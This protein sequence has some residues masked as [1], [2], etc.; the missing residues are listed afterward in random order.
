MAYMPGTGWNALA[1]GL[2]GAG[3]MFMN[4]YKMKEAERQQKA[5]DEEAATRLGLAT[6]SSDLAQKTYD[7]QVRGNKIAEAESTARLQLAQRDELRRLAQMSPGVRVT[8]QTIAQAQAAGMDMGQITDTRPD[9]TEMSVK[10][11]LSSS[12][13]P[14]ALGEG[15]IP[16]VQ[17]QQPEAGGTFFRTDLLTP[18]ERMA[19]QEMDLRL[20]SFAFDKEKQAELVRQFGV[21]MAQNAQRIAIAWDAAKRA[22][23]ED[24]AARAKEKWE[25]E[26][27]W[28]VQKAL[29]E[30]HADYYRSPRGNSGL[31][32]WLL[33]QDP[34]SNAPR[35]GPLSSHGDGS[36]ERPRR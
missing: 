5:A 15:A 26:V 33:N 1:A 20:D 2:Q 28:P 16:G 10:R 14:E 21:E 31:P 12:D 34:T 22:G 3:D 8:P 35:P 36:S 13:Y 19:Q 30:A 9:I 17:F 29:T 27:Q 7:E 23:R 18:G 6:K 25:R 24:E 32:P 11:A 4:M